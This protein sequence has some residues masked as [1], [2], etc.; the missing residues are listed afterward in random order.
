VNGARPGVIVPARPK[1][2][3][4]YRQEYLR[5]EAEDRARN[6][7]IGEQVSV[8]TGH[9]ERVFMTREWTP[10][11]PR[12]LEYKYYARGIGPVL[13]VSV[14]PELSFEKLIGIRRN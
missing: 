7:S 3:A 13:A 2:G 8:P 5:G 1:I 11:E 4:A 10:L 6:M 9:Y 12:A 14:S